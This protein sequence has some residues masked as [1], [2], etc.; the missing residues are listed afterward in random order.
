M[1][2]YRLN[3]FFSNLGRTYLADKIVTYNNLKLG[4]LRKKIITDI[5]NDSSKSR[6]NIN[7]QIKE[8]KKRLNQFKFEIKE[9]S[10]DSVFSLEESYYF[11][12]NLN[13]EQETTQENTSINL[14]LDSVFSEVENTPS[15]QEYNDFFFKKDIFFSG[16]HF[17]INKQSKKIK[18][19]GPNIRDLSFEEYQPMSQTAGQGGGKGI[20]IKT[21]VFQALKNGINQMLFDVSA[22][23]FAQ[24][25]FPYKYY[26]P[27]YEVFLDETGLED[28]K[29]SRWLYEFGIDGL[30]LPCGKQVKLR[31]YHCLSKEKNND[32]ISKPVYYSP[33]LIYDLYKFNPEN[34]HIAESL[35]LQFLQSH[36]ILVGEV[37]EKDWF[38]IL[39]RY[40]KNSEDNKNGVREFEIHEEL[41]ENIEANLFLE[42]Y[43]HYLS[44]KS[45]SRFDYN[46]EIDVYNKRKYEEDIALAENN[47]QRNRFIKFVKLVQDFAVSIRDI[48]FCGETIDFNLKSPDYVYLDIFNIE[49][50]IENKF[51]GDLC[52]I[53]LSNFF[54][55]ARK[56][57]GGNQGKLSQKVDIDEFGKSF[58]RLDSD[59]WDKLSNELLSKLHMD[60]RKYGFRFK[61]YSQQ[62]VTTNDEP[63]SRYYQQFSKTTYKLLGLNN[64]ITDNSFH[65]KVCNDFDFDDVKNIYL[66][67]DFN[68]KI[69]SLLNYKRAFTFL[70]FS[71]EKLNK[72]IVYTFPPI[73]SLYGSE[74][75][76]KGLPLDNFHK[77]L[78]LYK[79][80]CRLLKDKEVEKLLKCKF[81]YFDKKE[82]DIEIFEEEKQNG[83]SK[84]ETIEERITSLKKKIETNI[85]SVDE[86]REYVTLKNKL[87]FISK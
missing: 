6:T 76:N 57:S 39:E 74:T 13:N 58:G 2:D 69:A 24:Y 85:A 61:I 20:T 30:E 34:K 43:I 72:C 44:R 77:V 38:S 68:K 10:K 50:I 84:I 46:A 16:L 32:F 23:E 17:N 21:E 47:T 75:G 55:S 7:N 56:L 63:T 12:E 66:N 5:V 18:Y 27:N 53:I 49:D 78:A 28:S 37:H 45:T 81:S 86:R 14:S 29:M 1:D 65:S 59:G 11:I 41:Q 4:E 25:I 36:N 70:Q 87:K 15:I 8:S 31:Y 42:S 3:I 51:C 80:K 79:E 54:E 52:M 33:K 35:F 9:L 64:K 62:A 82:E 60:S 83:E 71:D 67:E 48:T 22:S 40:I 19:Q 73:Y 26:I